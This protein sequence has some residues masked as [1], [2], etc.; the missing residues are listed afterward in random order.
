MAKITLNQI[1][2]F[3]KTEWIL[4]LLGSL[5]III[6]IIAFVGP[7]GKNGGTENQ[8]PWQNNIYPGKTSKDQLE[9]IAG[10]PLKTEEQNGKTTYL[11]PTKSQYRPSKVEVSGNTVSVVKEQII[12]SEKG[13]LFDYFNKFGSPQLKLFG[14]YSFIAPG[15][16]W[17]ENGILV[18]GSEV[19]GTIFE[20]WYFKPTNTGE[21]LRSHPELSTELPKEKGL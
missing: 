12:G 2:N 14:Q 16:L 10:K 6:S 19:D 7:F 17:A 4:L 13:S 1:S 18:F 9:S 8:V 5:S 15:Y 11:Y 3:I 20:I 21:F